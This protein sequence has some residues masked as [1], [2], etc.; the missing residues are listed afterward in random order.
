MKNRFDWADIAFASK[1]PLKGAATFVLAPRDISSKRLIVLVKEL[2]ARGDI[3]FG[4]AKEPYVSGFEGQPQFRTLPVEAA[5]DLA[6]KIA[7]SASP[8]KLYVLEYFEQET[9]TIIEKLSPTHAIVVRGSYIQAFHTRSTFYTLAKLKIPFTYVSPF[10][11]EAEARSYESEIDTDAAELK[12]GDEL[13]LLGYAKVVAKQS[14]DYSFQTG[15]VLAEKKGPSYDVIATGYNKVIPYQTYA[16]HHGNSREDSYSTPNDANHYDTIHAEM[17][18]LV[19]AQ[20]AGL[21]LGGTTLFI[22]MLPCPNCART[23]SQTDIVEVVYS[24][25][26]SEGY[27]IQLLEACGKSV[28]RVVL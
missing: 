13:T 5:A 20:Q 27:A 3:V 7:H 21:S 15:C 24:I 9:D 4:V 18:L 26:H 11:D 25:D 16:M 17:Q 10:V 23:L 12:S 2:L 14:F 22:N 19:Q 28:R 1:K 6:A 8:H